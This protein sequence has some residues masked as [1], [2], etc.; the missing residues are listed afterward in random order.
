M[1]EELCHVYDSQLIL[2]SILLT[3]EVFARPE[4]ICIMCVSVSVSVSVCVSVS[5]FFALH[6]CGTNDVTQT[7]NADKSV[8]Q[9]CAMTHSQV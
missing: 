8:L 3:V 5:V 2:S 7:H 6:P 9:I 4:F 1:N